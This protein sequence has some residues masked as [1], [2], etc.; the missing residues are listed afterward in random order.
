LHVVFYRLSPER[1]DTAA[2]RWVMIGMVLLL[3]M[4]FGLSIALSRGTGLPDAALTAR[5]NRVMQRVGVAVMALALVTIPGLLLLLYVLV[6]LRP[7]NRMAHRLAVND[8][9]GAIRIG[10][11]QPPAKRDLAVRVN[12]VVAYMMAGRKEDARALLA[13]IE[14]AGP[15]PSISSQEQYHVIIQHLRGIVDGQPQGGP[16]GSTGASGR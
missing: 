15:D 1:F 9:A 3:A 2:F 5:V 13:E 11:A 10:E 4:W 12:L 8:A 14:S 7:S 6:R 16:D